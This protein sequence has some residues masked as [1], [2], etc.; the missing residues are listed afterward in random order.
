M[1]D[2]ELKLQSCTSNIEI[3]K[4]QLEE[5]M[6]RGEELR[7]CAEEER[8]KALSSLDE[9]I[10]SIEEVM[11]DIRLKYKMKKIQHYLK[12]SYYIGTFK[13]LISKIPSARWGGDGIYLG[14]K[15][16]ILPRD[17]INKFYGE[18][19]NTKEFNDV[20]TGNYVGA[21]EESSSQYYPR[22]QEIFKRSVASF[23][24]DIAVFDS[25]RIISERLDRIE[26]AIGL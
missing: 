10:E 14:P 22:K 6:A 12:I 1:T 17:E 5:E 19:I 25:L 8:K 7:L 26:R 23:E 3:L 11:D 20:L 24:K 21:D 13:T 9:K 2:T 18:I 4:R 15:I 16:E